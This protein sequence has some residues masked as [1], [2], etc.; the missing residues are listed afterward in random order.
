MSTAIFIRALLTW[1][2]DMKD[3]VNDTTSDRLIYLVKL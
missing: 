2:C 3:N 1:T